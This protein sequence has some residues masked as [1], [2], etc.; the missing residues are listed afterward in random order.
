[1]KRQKADGYK[2]QK[3]V[4]PDYLFANLKIKY[5][6]KIISQ[7]YPFDG[8][9][10]NIGIKKTH[11]LTHFHRNI[12]RILQKMMLYNIFSTLNR[13]CLVYKGFLS[14]EVKPRMGYKKQKV[15]SPDYLFANLK[16]KYYEKIISQKYPFDGFEKNVRVRTPHILTHFHRNITRILQK[17]CST[18]YFWAKIFLS[19]FLNNVF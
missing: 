11:I 7:K 1:M 15:V 16:I 2:K 18:T 3:A 10:K 4:S 13:N 14:D 19:M 9:E 8:F 12:T 17:Y 6:E 5:Y